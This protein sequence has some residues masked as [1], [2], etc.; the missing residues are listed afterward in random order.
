MPDDVGG[1]SVSFTAEA[2]QLKAEIDRLERRLQ[3]FNRA[4]GQ[5]SV[6][7]T[8]D[9]N[10]PGQRRMD[11]F[12]RDIQKGVNGT[13]ADGGAIGVKARVMLE[14]PTQA[15]IAGFRRTLQGLL[16]AS[17]VT[18]RVVP[19]FEG[20]SG[21]GGGGRAGGGGGGPAV[22]VPAGNVRTAKQ[23]ADLR[24]EHRN[25]ERASEREAERP[26]VAVAPPTST[27]SSAAAAAAGTVSGTKRAQRPGVA[28]TKQDL[29]A[30][31][32]AED[33]HPPGY[34]RAQLQTVLRQKR[35]HKEDPPREMIEAEL[36][37]RDAHGIRGFHDPYATSLRNERRQAMRRAN[38][39]RMG[40]AGSGESSYIPPPTNPADYEQRNAELY[41]AL[42]RTPPGGQ[43]GFMSGDVGTQRSASIGHYAAIDPERAVPWTASPIGKWA[44]AGLL[45]RPAQHL[46]DAYGP[47]I[48]AKKIGVNEALGIKKFEGRGLNVAEL[49]RN[50]LKVFRTAG[51]AQIAAGQNWY[52]DAGSLLERMSEGTGLSR[53]QA[54]SAGAV[55]STNADW[56]QNIRNAQDFFSALREGATS[57]DE[58]NRSIQRR[59]GGKN[60]TTGPITE[61]AWRVSQT[62]DDQ[63]DQLLAHYSAK[64]G[65]SAGFDNPKLRAFAQGLLGNEQA[66]TVDRHMARMMSG[67][68]EVAGDQ[69]AHGVFQL[70]GQRA[71]KKA[72]LTPAQ[73]QAIAW[74]SALGS[75]IA[76]ADP[77][78]MASGQGTD[79]VYADLAQRFKQQR[80]AQRIAMTQPSRARA[81]GLSAPEAA[82]A[83]MA[84]GGPLGFHSFDPAARAGLPLPDKPTYHSTS[85]GLMRSPSQRFDEGGERYRSLTAAGRLDVREDTES[86]H[87]ERFQRQHAARAAALNE[88]ERAA[89]SQAAIKGARMRQ[90]RARV[91]DEWGGFT[92]NPDTQQF[93]EA[94]PGR[95]QG[96]WLSGVGETVSLTPEQAQDPRQSKAAIDRLYAQNK[97]LMA[98]MRARGETPLIGGFHDKDTGRV[99]YDI[100]KRDETPQDAMRTQR[101]RGPLARG[102]Y[103]VGSGEALYAENNEL[104]MPATPIAGTIANVRFDPVTGELRTGKARRASAKRVGAAADVP[105]AQPPMAAFASIDQP[106]Y[107]RG[108]GSAGGGGGGRPPAPSGGPPDERPPRRETLQELLDTGGRTAAP[109]GGQTDTAAGPAVWAHG[110]EDPLI[111]AA[112]L[113]LRQS[114]TAENIRS[115]GTMIAQQAA[116]LFGGRG[117]RQEQQARLAEVLSAYDSAGT[118]AAKMAEKAAK[119]KSEFHDLAEGTD[120][121][122][123]D[124]YRVRMEETAA[125]AE[126]AA[127]AHAA[128]RGEV[129][130]ATDALTPA[131]SGLRNLVIGFGAGLGT[132]F[133]FQAASVGLEKLAGAMAHPIDR[134]AD[135]RMTADR[136]APSLGQS[137]RQ[138]HGFTEGALDAQ[139]AQTGMGRAAQQQVGPILEHR[140]A[141]EAGNAAFTEQLDLLRAASFYRNNPQ[142]GITEGTGGFMGTPIGATQP[143]YER[144]LQSGSPVGGPMDRGLDAAG[145]GVLPGAG[146]GAAIGTAIAPGIG[147]VLGGLMGGLVGAGIGAATG[148]SSATFAERFRSGDLT[149]SETARHSEFLTSIGSLNEAAARAN[150]SLAATAKYISLIGD[151]SEEANAKVEATAR[152]FER[153]GQQA[154]ADAARTLRFA[155]ENPRTGRAGDPQALA[156]A[157]A[158]GLTMPEETAFLGQSARQM[159]AQLQMAQWQGNFRRQTA[160]PGQTFMSQLATGR[161]SASGAPR[162][163]RGSSVVSPDVAARFGVDMSG[164]ASANEGLEGT[165]SGAA[166]AMQDLM[167]DAD[168]MARMSGPSNLA[169][170]FREA[171]EAAAETA[172]RI[173]EITVRGS[174]MQ[175]DLQ[176]RQIGEQQ[177]VAGQALADAKSFITGLPSEGPG[178]GALGVLQSE[179]RGLEVRSANLGFESTQLGLARNQRQ[180]NVQRAIAGFA[181][182]GATGEE[183]AARMRY[184]EYEADIAQKQQDIGVEQ[185]GIERARFG[186]QQ[187]QISV[188]AARAVET[189]NNQLKLLNES[190]AVTVQLQVDSE[191]VERERARLEEE[192]ATVGSFIQQATDIV[193]NNAA[194]QAA[195]VAALGGYMS[196][197]QSKLLTAFDDYLAGVEERLD[198]GIARLGGRRRRSAT[199]DYTGGQQRTDGGPQAAGYFGNV[200]GAT[201]M[202]VGE[203]GPETIAILRNPRTHSMPSGGGGGGG[204]NVQITITGNTIGGSE[205]DTE[206]FAAM[207]ARKVEETMSRRSALTGL[208][209]PG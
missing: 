75:E 48:T 132:A 64:K 190:A 115:P 96:P 205:Q 29:A 56:A 120:D 92:L 79:P 13:T 1:I 145:K 195:A 20:G 165:V 24:A 76:G 12:R 108:F 32:T 87:E 82:P 206:A 68:R 6:K 167:R 49:E 189:L 194:Q 168:R 78:G 26:S 186:N 162:A 153:N 176:L 23:V 4:H 149:E 110:S 129:K 61:K 147:T 163:G 198:D 208:R 182:P 17:P 55:F 161:F 59:R 113:R 46:Y 171:S 121:T 95:S 10:M 150:P 39:A 3:T 40:V 166:D 155:V 172:A 130:S 112:R 142:A 126:R 131:A 160:I 50:L 14:A 164:L 88:R 28:V 21:G 133:A 30:T 119:A 74:V 152:Y 91:K 196:E 169:S 179:A 109:R 85:R 52:R 151:T 207:I 140:A 11:E 36:I 141:L 175:F 18:I 83:P 8:A 62:P 118:A 45:S 58:V 31:W 71:A 102:A 184:A 42:G 181:A 81:T 53:T 93:I 187:E 54:I 137:V 35:L 136:L 114:S 173:R 9:L 94:T 170:G 80:V 22:A 209:G 156:V 33:L 180:I 60:A 98:E 66:F 117:Q 41:R 16:N 124:Q 104:N 139:Y 204:V 138:L 69:R 143:F 51:A 111:A 2:S 100:V 97:S 177:R 199:R 34:T 90:M 107:A 200:A 192:L 70:A 157:S 201:Q 27:T 122:R 134:M 144:L 105:L 127:D 77:Y 73:L 148:G 19:Q 15:Q 5:Q 185:A 89:R 43:R 183:R 72:G 65:G 86:Q 203:A 158:Q 7:L 128:L 197:Y 174:R 84:A 44:N 202:I 125:A 37:R 25:A 116:S 188:S 67:G 101:A 159:H 106:A 146:V 47:N 103:N 154:Q 99:D 38:A 63:I 178:G 123:R 193:T 191:A 135:F 57:L